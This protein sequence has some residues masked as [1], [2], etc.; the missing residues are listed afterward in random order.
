MT[1]KRPPQQIININPL[2]SE[3]PRSSPA[4]LTL[5]CF[6]ILVGIGVL[7]ALIAGAIW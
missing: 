1:K 6:V 4:E 5:S 7:G 3:P 2:P